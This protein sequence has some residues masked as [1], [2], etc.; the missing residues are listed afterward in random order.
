MP[1]SVKLFIVAACAALLTADTPSPP[2][3]TNTKLPTPV[4][5]DTCA[6]TRAPLSAI[7]WNVAMAPG[8]NP[9]YTERRRPI[10][11]AVR[12]LEYDV[13]C[14]QEAWNDID[15][16]AIAAATELPPENVFA[17]ET[18]GLGED[19]AD[20]CARH[21][22]DT[23]LACTA[24]ECEDVASEDTTLCAMQRCRAELK[25][26]FTRH[27]RC[28]NCLTA[29]VGRSIQ[30]IAATC[31]TKSASRIY[32]GRNGMMLLSRW[33]L[34]DRDVVFLPSSYAN[35]LV[36]LA[37]VRVPGVPEP[38]E[39]ACTHI[40]SPQPI[41]PF[42]SGL[43][44]WED[45]Q[46]AQ[47]RVVIDAA[48]TR[49]QDRPA[50]FLADMNVGGASGRMV[51]DY[52]RAAWDDL[53]AAGWRDPAAEATLPFCS[54]CGENTV[55][56]SPGGPG[57]LLDHVVFRNPTSGVMLEPLCTDR[58]LDNKVKARG[59]DAAV[60]ATHLSDHYAVRVKFGFR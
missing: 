21:D 43:A 14:I 53:I 58:L 47:M 29:Q 48:L 13:L 19:E 3:T 23:L 60:I 32:G 15:K 42:H 30:D 12:R 56:W 59:R 20:I 31:T 51:L 10:T 25:L 26:L 40:S 37:R 28:L 8:M 33:P 36:L 46:R 7:T 11:D 2:P 27:R 24:S 18:A 5:G 41:P 35:R 17:H 9:L 6:E 1:I 55:R 22:V 54:V 39:L 57:F 16:L 4:F 50:I 44:T 52:S 34:Y 49:A 45:E 38:I